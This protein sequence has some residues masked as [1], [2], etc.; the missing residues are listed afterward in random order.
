MLTVFKLE[1][2]H[3]FA[4]PGIKSALSTLILVIPLL[5]GVW[6]NDLIIEHKILLIAITSLLNYGFVYY[7][8]KKPKWK[9]EDMLNAMNLS[10]WGNNA[11][12]YRANV[13]TYNSRKKSLSIKHISASMLGALDRKLNLKTCQGCAGE[14]FRTKRPMVVDLT[15]ET[16]EQYEINP[17]DVWSDM[18]SVT[19]FPI[20]GDDEHTNV[21]GVL[22]VDSDYDVNSAGFFKNNVIRVVSVYSDWISE[23]L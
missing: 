5:L 11:E 20:F 6:N 18:R 1:I 4:V 22:N 14:A 17:R 21:I 19:S 16:H 2:K 12:H 9:I 13:M 15:Q 3:F 10:L 8:Y 23:L 7:D